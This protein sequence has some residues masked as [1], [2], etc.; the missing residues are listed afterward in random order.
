M[1]TIREFTAEDTLALQEIWNGIIKEGK[2]FPQLEYL[3]DSEAYSFFSGQSYTGV[4][5]GEAGEAIGFYTLHPNNVG[6]CGHIANCS[7]GV[8]PSH[9][10]N[11]AGQALVEDSLRK[12]KELGFTLMQFNAVVASNL[13]AMH[14]YE[15]IGFVKLGTIPGGFLYSDGR[16]VDIIL[17]YFDLQTI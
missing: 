2:A 6:R 12:A 15:K 11:K 9:R 7:Y 16:Y 5:E 14:I 1:A 13:P 3:E 17:Y 4:A 10:G 8:S